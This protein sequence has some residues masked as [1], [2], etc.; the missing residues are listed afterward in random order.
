MKLARMEK[1]T[2][3]IFLFIIKKKANSLL[4]HLEHF[5]LFTML[6]QFAAA[7]NVFFTETDIRN[8]ILSL[9]KPF[10]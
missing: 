5:I 3:T 8:D 4:K 2:Q 10:I 7:F 6:S 1:L 9:N